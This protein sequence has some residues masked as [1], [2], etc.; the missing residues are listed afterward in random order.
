MKTQTVRTRWYNLKW[1]MKCWW[2]LNNFRVPHRAADMSSSGAKQG[3][4]RTKKGDERC[5]SLILMLQMHCCHILMRWLR[6]ILDNL[7]FTFYILLRRHHKHQYQTVLLKVGVWWSL[8][9]RRSKPS[10]R[11]FLPFMGLGSVSRVWHGSWRWL[12]RL[13]NCKA[14][15]F[16]SWSLPGFGLF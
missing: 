2:R 7:H 13:R 8:F 9:P 16:S 5:S 14:E 11:R 1:S 3:E 12:R 4:G 15:A 6:P 10:P